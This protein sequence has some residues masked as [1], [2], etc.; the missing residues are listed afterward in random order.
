[1]LIEAKIEAVLFFKNEPITVTALSR[2]LGEK[3]DAV[4]KALAN[5]ETT[6]AD[7]GVTLMRKEGRE[8]SVALVTSAEASNL[9]ETITR[10]ELSRDLSKVG[11]ETLTI[12]LYRGP[13]TRSQ[14]DYIRGVNSTFTLRNLL[15]R[16]LIEK[17]TSEKD[18]RS[19]LY[20]PTFELLQYLGLKNVRDLPEYEQVESA[21]ETF[22]TEL[23]STINP[24]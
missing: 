6:L 1:M 21:V 11:L 10:E 14:I 7:R 4:E 16:G 19:F 18:A 13:I 15:V 12:I 5:L 2:M 24:N 8:E 23:E 22:T 17:E 20:R 3:S 9:I